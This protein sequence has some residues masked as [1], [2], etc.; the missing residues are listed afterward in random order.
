MTVKLKAYRLTCIAIALDKRNLS[1]TEVILI[2]PAY[3]QADINSSVL[4]GPMH[5][6]A[7]CVRPIIF[8]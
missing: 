5:M 4:L 7:I 6:Q 8:R 3:F 2:R 1:L